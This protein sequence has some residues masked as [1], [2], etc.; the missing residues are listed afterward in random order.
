MVL[1]TIAGVLAP[2]GPKGRLSILIFHR[3]LPT[4]DPLFPGEQDARRFDEVLGWMARWFRVLPLDAAVTHLGQGTLPARAAAITFDD[5][6]ADNATEALPLL[7]KHGM[8]ATFFVATSFLNGGRMWNDSIIESVRRCRA[9]SLDLRDEGMGLH[10]LGSVTERR[11]AIEALIAQIKYQ[12]A[13]ERLQSVDCIERAAGVELP[14]DLMMTGA[15]VRQLRDAGMQIG[16][17]TCSHPILARIDAADAQREMADSKSAL[18]TLLNEEVALFAYPNGKPG[19]D[20][21]AE[22]TQ[23]AKAA[24][25]T[26]AVSTAP[27]VSTAG[28]DLFQLPRFSP[29]DQTPLRYGARMLDNLRNTRPGVV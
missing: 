25:F 12:D 13:A 27:G 15:Q 7:R 20:Y 5:G 19:K 23:M 22:H 18:E 2:A 29:W 6:Y 1:K 16:A 28:M 26:A 24:G 3:V 9:D 8:T 10:P 11:E 21:L 17:H 14:S 4:P